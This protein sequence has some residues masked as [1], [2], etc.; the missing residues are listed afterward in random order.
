MIGLQF[1]FIFCQEPMG[2]EFCFCV[3][4]NYVQLRSFFQG[5]STVYSS[6][7]KSSNTRSNFSDLKE[8]AI[9]TFK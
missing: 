1:L 4:G 7:L 6:L 8:F 5:N 2:V 3:V 9:K